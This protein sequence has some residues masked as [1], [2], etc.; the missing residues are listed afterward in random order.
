M[1][2]A[3]E[4]PKAAPGVVLPTGSPGSCPKINVP[5]QTVNEQLPKELALTEAPFPTTSVPTE[6]LLAEVT[7]AFGVV[8]TATMLLAGPP[9]GPLGP[10]V[11]DQFVEVVQRPPLTGPTQV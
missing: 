5:K 8:I 2:F 6:M 9:F 11:G 4:A 10:A 1:T 3:P 7:A